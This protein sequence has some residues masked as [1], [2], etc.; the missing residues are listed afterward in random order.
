[1]KENLHR[2]K[3]EIQQR[4]TEADRGQVE[5]AELGRR[6]K[7]AQR[8]TVKWSL[9]GTHPDK[10]RLAKGGSRSS[11]DNERDNDTPIPTSS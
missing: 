10:T 4:A 2:E 6:E 1:M 8:S 3:T 9:H 5:E 11:T 7:R